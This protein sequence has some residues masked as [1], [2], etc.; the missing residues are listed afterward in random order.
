MSEEF[1]VKVGV[2][3]DTSKL[4]SQIAKVKPSNKI[5]CDV[6]LNEASVQHIVNQLNDGIKAFGKNGNEIKFTADVTGLKKDVASAVKD[7]TGKSAAN[8]IKLNADTSTAKKELSG[9]TATIE[10]S[11]NGFKELRN[12]LAGMKF[13]NSSI[14]AFMKELENSLVTV[15]KVEASFK[16]DHTFTLTVKGADEAEK[17]IQAVITAKEKL[18]KEGNGTGEWGTSTKVTH[19]LVDSAADAKKAAAEAKQAVA[20]EAAAIKQAKAEEAA[21]AKQAAAEAKAAAQEQAAAEKE[22]AAAAK[23]AAKEQEAAAQS[24]AKAAAQRQKLIDTYKAEKQSQVDVDSKYNKINDPTKDLTSAYDSYKNA[25]KNLFDTENFTDDVVAVNEYNAALE[26]VKNQ[27]SIVS[28]KE[29]QAAAAAKA[30]ASAQKEATAAMQLRSKANNLSQSMD[31]WLKRNSAAA[32]TFGGQ[33][34][35][36]QAE[37][38]SCDATR[39][40]G[41]QSEFK[42]ITTQAEI[43]GKTGLT[44]VDGLKQKFAE[45]SSY[46]SAAS[47]IM[48]G[49][50]TVK[51]MAQNVLDVDTQM[52]ELKRVTDLTTDQYAG[53]YDRLISSAQ[54]YGTQLTDLISAT[55]DWSRAGF[56]ADVAAGLA[57][58]TSVY[59]HIADLDYDTSAENL[60]TAYK[61]FQTQLDE[62][63]GNDETAA[64]THI[65]DVYNEIDNNYATT[66]AD[67]GEAVKRSAS[68]L[69]LA[70]NSLEE[71]AGM[72]TGITEV[73]QDPEKVGNSL[74]VLSMRIRGKLSCHRTR[75]VCTLCSY[76][77]CYNNKNIE[78]SYIRQ[79]A[80]V[81]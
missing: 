29:K 7:V 57:E 31:L 14:D 17:K 80:R 39:L 25:K 20:E 69:S 42:T 81:A 50:Q 21:A 4:D 38:Q 60:L 51:E 3:L 73:T 26:T 23:A 47:I 15:D 66:A 36:L 61:G 13:D 2:E 35:S 54:E 53:I 45:L 46:F 41:I 16:D 5:K 12:Q 22:A 56:D 64:V 76:C 75:K 70:G 78:D 19:T 48:T 49:I 71:T 65:A 1:K 58:I 10:K 28:D 34:R 30:E 9:L 33:I 68:A 43:A 40:S 37:L 74:K 8:N 18:D 6:E 62:Q 32:E 77:L 59:Q 52:T 79:S 27:L 55:A 24:A 72:V 11:E 63:F 44:F 67:I